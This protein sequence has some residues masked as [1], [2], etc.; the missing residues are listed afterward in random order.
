MRPYHFRMSDDDGTSKT[1]GYGADLLRAVAR[2]RHV[3]GRKT[4]DKETANVKESAKGDDEREL[5]DIVFGGDG[6][7][8]EGED[9][10][11]LPGA[12]VGC[13]LWFFAAYSHVASCCWHENATSV[14]NFFWRV[15]ARIFFF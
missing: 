12:K 9:D 8:S 4:H 10:D 5:E 3:V 14:C 13:R 11:A 1:E 6:P 15:P 2:K 7:D